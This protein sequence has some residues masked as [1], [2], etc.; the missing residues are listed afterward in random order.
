MFRLSVTCEDK[1]FRWSANI[2]RLY[3]TRTKDSGSDLTRVNRRE[4][5]TFGLVCWSILAIGE[6]LPRSTSLEWRL[7]GSRLAGRKRKFEFRDED[8]HSRETIVS[9]AYFR[10]K[11]WDLFVR[12]I[13]GG[14]GMFSMVRMIDVRY[15][16]SDPI[17]DLEDHK[18]DNSY[19]A[20]IKGSNANMWMKLLNSKYVL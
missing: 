1:E 6:H 15:L 19:V 12:P 17:F 9:C 10:T 8:K 4:P 3:L 18:R 11:C 2:E 13:K 20:N 5:E 16:F 14:V 7:P